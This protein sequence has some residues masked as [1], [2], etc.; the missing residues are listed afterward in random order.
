MPRIKGKGTK[1]IEVKKK[2][3][4][5]RRP[6]PQPSYLFFHSLFLAPLPYYVHLSPLSERLELAVKTIHVFPCLAN[7]AV[8]KQTLG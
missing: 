4:M 3:D 1:V 8:K 2:D 7:L 6:S 5:R